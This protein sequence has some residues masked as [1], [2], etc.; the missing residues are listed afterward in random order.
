MDFKKV[1]RLIHEDDLSD[2]AIG[3]V[4]NVHRT[5]VAKYRRELLNQPIASDQMDELSVDALR[6]TLNLKRQL[7]TK[8]WTE[9]DWEKVAQRMSSQ[10]GMVLTVLHD[11]YMQQA[12]TPM[13]YV[14]FCRQFGK[15][16]SQRG[17]VMR[18]VRVAGEEA[19][20]D[21]SGKRPRVLDTSTGRYNAAELFVGALGH[22]RLIFA[23][24]VPDQ[25]TQSWIKA[26]ISMFEYCGGVPKYIV[27]DNLKAAVISQRTETRNLILNSTFDRAMQHYGVTPLPTRVRSPRDKGLVEQ[28]VL[29]AKRWITLALSNEIFHSIAEL[30]E[31]ISHRL[32]RINEKPMRR[33]AGKSRLQIFELEE[34]SRLKPLP[35]KPFRNLQH[36]RSVRVPTDYHI[37]YEGNFYSV[38]HDLVGEV[39]DLFQDQEGISL[40]HS[41]K[42]VAIHPRQENVGKVST[43]RH[44]QPENHRYL[45]DHRKRYFNTWGRYQAK[46]IDRYL[47]CHLAAW[48]NPNA[49]DKC[50]RKL[51]DLVDNH[52]EDIVIRAA[53]WILTNCPDE[54]HIKRLERLIAQP[55]RMDSPILRDDGDEM[56]FSHKN[57]RGASY[58]GRN[59]T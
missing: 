3:R 6:E 30:N 36:V 49:T 41:R 46:P 31:A 15:H 32:E 37:E 56:N 35:Q 24:A 28:S 10:K 33:M 13:N 43:L 9:P 17:L 38:P 4:C 44:H 40:F 58:Y 53:D 42:R 57:I 29:H 7:P 26:V 11:E 51:A 8:N 22:S 20:V 18:H 19:F 52:G 39:V 47:R 1:L 55:S 50:A 21:F 59:E 45:G 48:K 12:E 54:P 16:Q 2:V 5:T 25:S 14:R 23:T 27:P 34:K